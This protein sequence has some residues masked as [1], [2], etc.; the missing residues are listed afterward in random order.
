MFLFYIGW[1]PRIADLAELARTN[2]VS[3]VFAIIFAIVSLLQDQHTG[4]SK[5]PSDN[6]YFATRPLHIFN[7]MVEKS[8]VV[9]SLDFSLSLTLS[10]GVRST[11]SCRSWNKLTKAKIKYLTTA[12]TWN[13]FSLDCL[14]M[15]ALVCSIGLLTSSA[16]SAT[17]IECLSDSRHGHCHLAR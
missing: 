1:L 14:L 12:H 2:S 9:F 17:C 10:Q 16:N 4:A 7:T 15:F 11:N 3:V 5:S 6:L 13:R 8:L